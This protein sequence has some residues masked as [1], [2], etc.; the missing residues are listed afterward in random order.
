MGL[1]RERG[2]AVYFLLEVGAYCCFISLVLELLW[3]GTLIV[4]IN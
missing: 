4:R 2:T 3:Y 1:H